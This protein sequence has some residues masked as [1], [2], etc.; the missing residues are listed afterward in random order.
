MNYKKITHAEL[1]I[2]LNYLTQFFNF[3]L[4][5]RNNYIIIKFPN[6]DT[7]I[8][9]FQDQ[10]DKYY[11]ETGLRYYLFHVTSDNVIPCSTYF[12]VDMDTNLIKKIPDMLFKYNQ[13]TYSFYT[14]TRSPCDYK[15]IKK[16]VKQ[17]Q[18]LLLRVGNLVIE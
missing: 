10:W 11:Y 18:K 15:S 16:C 3:N 17:F 9:I 13:E 7:H 8:T 6:C 4:Y 5:M 12:L 2:K 14:S 1:F